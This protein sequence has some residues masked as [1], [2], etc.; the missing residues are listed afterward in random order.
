MKKLVAILALCMLCVFC[1][2]GF[3]ACEEK[4]GDHTHV[5]DSGVITKQATCAE[6]GELTIT[7]S[8]C[9]KTYTQSIPM[10][11]HTPSGAVEENRVEPICVEDGSYDS[12]V[13][14]SVCNTEL[15]RETTVIPATGEHHFVNGS[16]TLCGEV[17][18]PTDSDYFTFTLLDDGTYAIKAKDIN[19]MPAEIVLPSTYDNK[20]VTSIGYS[21]FYRC[22]NLTSIAIP[23][24]VT[25]IG[26][27]AFYGCSSLKSINI[28][29]SV[30]S[31]GEY[32][33][34][35]CSSLTSVTIGNSV[36]SIGDSAFE[37]CSSLTSVTIGNSVTSIGGY[38]FWQCRSLYYIVNKSNLQLSIDGTNN[39][40][41][42]YYAKAIEDKDGKVTYIEN[43]I[44]IENDFMFEYVSS[45]YRLKAYI[46]SE[47]TVTLPLTYNGNSYS[48]YYMRGVNNVIIP[49]GVTSIGESAF[50]DCRSLTNITIPDSV[51]SIGNDAFARCPCIKTENGISYVDKWLI[52]ADT[53]ITVAVLKDDT[54]VIA[55][56]AFRSF[57]KLTSITIPDSVTRIGEYAFYDC[58]KLTSITI[59]DSV[60]SIGKRAFESC[61]SLQY[62]EYDN[63]L[64]L[65]N[66]NNPYVVL[67]KVK[68][69][70]IN[71]CAIYNGTK[72]IYMNAFYNCRSLTNIT[73]PDS[74]TSIGD[75]AFES[76]GSLTSIIIPDSVT[77]I[78]YY[79]FYG[80]GSLTSITIP[81]SVTSIGQYAFYY[82]RSLTSI[83]IPDSVTSIGSSAFAGCSSLTS[84]TIGNSVTSIGHSAF[85]YCSSLTSITLPYSVTSI[86]SYAFRDCSKLINIT[87]PDSVTSVGESAFA[88]CSNLTSIAIPDSVISIGDCAFIG[89]S[90]LT[91]II[92][93]ENNTYYSIQDGILYNKGKTEIIQVPKG[94]SGAIILPNSLTSI[95][96]SAFSGCSSL[97]SITIPDSVTS[98][99]DRAFEECSSLTSITIGNSVTSIG[100]YAFL[101]CSSLTSVIIPNS[102]TS[103]GNCVFRGCDNL[104]SVYYKGTAEMWNGITIGAGNRILLTV[105]VYFYSETYPANFAEDTYWH[106]DG[107]IIAIW[108]KEADPTPTHT[109]EYTTTIVPPSCIEQGY[110][111]YECSCGDKKIDNFVAVTAHNYVNGVCSVC[112]VQEPTP[113]W[114]FT[115]NLSLLD[116]TY[117]IGSK[118]RYNMPAEVILP[119]THDGKAVK[120]IPN[121]AFAD[122]RI[123]SII[124]PDSVTS[125]GNNAFANCSKLTSVTIPDS[126]TSIG[127]YAFSGCS[128]LT[129]I[130]IPDSITRIEE[131]AF[132]GCS[133][134]ISITIPDSVTSIG[135]SA[136]KGCSRL[137]SVTIGK[138]VTSIG[139]EAFQTCMSLTDINFN[140]TKMQWNVISKGRDW[141]FFVPSN[142][143][144]HCTDGDVAI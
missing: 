85:E 87:I 144:V 62:N 26:R 78:G 45:E 117:S 113:D 103:I 96:V 94:I 35:G 140:G 131:C 100:D 52:K 57:S 16:C 125:I 7:C 38:A 36:T 55:D 124:I 122:C 104:K 90:S 56:N 27:W 21:A 91:S 19:N 107:L 139:D 34:H 23:D 99:G 102:V 83:T 115:F 116:H 123:K 130:T 13:Y 42:A 24:S 105:K 69:T 25:S 135:D 137:T 70:D 127:R 43:P 74:V 93:L 12:V 20:L 142:C 5:Y 92:G 33:F 67:V 47:N 126:V 2:I 111:L 44:F 28:P 134:L 8:S 3:S 106:Y 81:D 114:Y 76:C 128:S 17:L 40:L 53:S 129:S 54:L 121:S 118:D 73:I 49:Q 37:D 61:S 138:S 48:I 84:I 101:W 82:C 136:F 109:H 39:G 41:V 59:P 89:C 50:Y 141:K 32:A 75:S 98:I 66:E 120:Y 63:G 79:A 18:P 86:G 95:R 132:G 31:I 72:S 60:T 51:T 97:T 29:D 15:S 65:G 143:V 22:Y 71:S 1:A 14:C 9:G 68:S 108:V 11:A 64:Y 119:S 112:G 46:G 80:C 77:S 4:D 110:T 10:V 88:Y 30:T 133:S 58:S 6:Q